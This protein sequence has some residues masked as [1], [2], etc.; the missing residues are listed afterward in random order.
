MLKIF[1]LVLSFIFA[2]TVTVSAQ[3]V[4][5]SFEDGPNSGNWTEASTN[6]GTPICNLAAC[7][8][9]GGPCLPNTGDN[10]VWFGGANSVETG[11]VE[12]SIFIDQ[13]TEATITMM[14]YIPEPGDGLAADRIELSIDGTVLKTISVQDSATYGIAYT[15]DS[16]DV[17][18]Y[19]DSAFHLVKIEGFQTTAAIANILVDDVELTVRGVTSTLFAEKM[20][21]AFLLY[22]NHA[23]D[24]VNLEF[25]GISGDATVSISSLNGAIVTQE[26]LT[27]VSGR[28]F[29]YDT[30]NLE[31]GIYFVNVSNKDGVATQKLV[32]MH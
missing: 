16:I 1:T 2:L 20:E 22:P 14:V 18:A 24:F 9:C 11:S 26:T 19:A 17:S 10:Y 12:Q 21:E 30:S 3:F 5:G 27:N 6:F 15:L 8:D 4:D 25:K 7:G 13:G 32:V 31:A 29:T 28:T 23:N